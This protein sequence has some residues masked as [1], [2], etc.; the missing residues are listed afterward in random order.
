MKHY[1]DYIEVPDN[2]GRYGIFFNRHIDVH[3]HM[4][5]ITLLY[6]AGQ[7]VVT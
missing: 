4:N 3:N 1:D 7:E 2:Q 5:L 6:V